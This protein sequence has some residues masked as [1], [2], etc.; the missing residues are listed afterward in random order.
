M[1]KAGVG[2]LG[3]KRKMGTKEKREPGKCGSN[4]IGPTNRTRY[5]QFLQFKL[6]SDT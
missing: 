5:H 4:T 1:R 2:Y 3:D 6:K